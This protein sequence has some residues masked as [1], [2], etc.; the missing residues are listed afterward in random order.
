M[1]P[2]AAL[3]LF[4][5][6]LPL[7]IAFHP[8][9]LYLFGTAFL[10]ASVASAWN[11]LETAGQIS[12]GHAAF[13]GAGAYASSLVALRTN[14]SPQLALLLGALVGGV[15]AVP[16][17]LASHV[18]RSASLALATFAY[19]EALRVI[20]RNWDGLTGGGAGLIGIPPVDSAGGRAEGYYLSLLLLVTALAVGRAV[21]R[22]RLG[23]AFAAIREREDRA[24]ALGLAPTPVKLAAFV[25]SGGLTGLGGA[26]YAHTV[27]SIQPD[28]V[29]GPSFS[30]LPL[31]MATFG[32][33]RAPLGPTLGALV[34]HL[35][36]QL[37][38]HPLLPRLHQLPYALALIAVALALPKGLVGLFMTR[39]RPA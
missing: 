19:A 3:I 27:G 37:V 30:L 25:L 6:A 9:S 28:L 35:T 34:L 32:G 1:I 31:I 5:L 36:S 21:E 38:L 12:F 13:F 29:F 26:L 24:Q 8:Y 22:S 33:I 11:L 18:L 4:A 7:V 14:L 16:L 2:T 20:A 10:W 23:L 15:T 39:R 17:G